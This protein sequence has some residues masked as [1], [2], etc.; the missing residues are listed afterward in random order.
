VLG[1]LGVGVEDGAG[2]LVRLSLLLL[3]VTIGVLHIDVDHLLV[4][5]LVAWLAV[6]AIRAV[7]PVGGSGEGGRAGGRE[8]AC[9]RSE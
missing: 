5:M 1:L 2:D 3:G 6:L 8:G 9:N 7:L 4:G